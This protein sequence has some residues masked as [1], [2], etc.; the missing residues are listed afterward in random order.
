MLEREKKVLIKK[1]L[2]TQNEAWRWWTVFFP[3]SKEILWSFSLVWVNFWCFDRKWFFLRLNQIIRKD[4]FLPGIILS[5]V[6]LAPFLSQR[7]TVIGLVELT[8]KRRPTN[9]FRNELLSV[10]TKL[11]QIFNPFYFS[12]LVQIFM[13]KS[14]MQLQ[15]QQ[16]VAAQQ[17][18]GHHMGPH[19]GGGPMMR[20]GSSSGSE[21]GNGLSKPHQCQQCLKS[22]SSNHQLVQHIRVH[23]GEKPYKCSY[24]DRRFKQLSH[25]QQHTRLHTGNE[26]STFLRPIK[27]KTAFSHSPLNIKLQRE[28][29]I[30]DFAAFQ[31]LITLSFIFVQIIWNEFKQKNDNN[32]ACFNTLLLSHP[33]LL[34]A[35]N[36]I[37]SIWCWSTL[38]LLMLKYWMVHIEPVW[39]WRKNLKK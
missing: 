27:L 2:K 38:L 30:L 19:G 21:S 20:P 37:A 13:H 35:P 39:L 22:F 25:V 10:S 26:S 32:G 31:F 5:R 16:A 6:F 23:T 29:P 3:S 17:Q 15:Q 12:I 14:A 28:H 33:T 11:N 24:C 36:F 9:P 1:W 8:N 18:G 7:Q 4:R 34:M